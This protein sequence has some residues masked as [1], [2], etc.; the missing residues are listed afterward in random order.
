MYRS[1][2]VPF[3]RAKYT[4]CNE[5]LLE[6]AFCSPYISNDGNEWIC[7]ICDNAFKCRELPVQS[8]GNGLK[9]DEIPSELSNLN[10]LEI[11][12]ICLR[13][14]FMK[15]V[16]LLVGKQRGIHGATVI[17]P[18]NIDNICTVLPCLP[19]KSDIIP[20]KL[21]RKLTYKS[22]YLFDFVDPQKVMQAL[23]Y[24]KCNNPLYR[25]IDINFEW[26][27]ES[28]H[29][30]EEVLYNLIL[31]PSLSGSAAIESDIS[32]PLVNTENVN[33]PPSCDTCYNEELPS[34]PVACNTPSHNNPPSHTQ[35]YCDTCNNE[36]LPSPPV[37]SNTPS[38][39]NSDNVQLTLPSDDAYSTQVEAAKKRGYT[40][41]N[42][43]G[44]GNSF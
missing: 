31:N 11:H 8:V 36:E 17:V 7:T 21:K 1:S 24:L 23:T 34:H 3:K 44:N 20:I 5:E 25:N 43:H 4:N 33:N 37:A 35:N 12:L 42:V 22:H 9:L 26:V 19:S 14:P 18:S 15:L 38:R 6:R 30:N 13:I 2:V 27:H 40:V 39:N 28:M 32:S 41:H 29:D 16:N 10:P